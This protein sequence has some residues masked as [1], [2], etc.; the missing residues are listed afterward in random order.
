MPR[1]DA[2][3][4]C[5]QSRLAFE[6]MRGQRSTSR[7]VKTVAQ[8]VLLTSFITEAG[9]GL[10][11]LS[12]VK[13]AERR[14]LALLDRGAA[15]GDWTVPEAMLDLLPSVINEHDRQLREVRLGVVTAAVERL[16]RMI[17][18]ALAQRTDTDV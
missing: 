2:D 13:E 9:H 8:A 6:A 11:D 16:E 3:A 4:M 12:L 7:E 17:V 10:L 18:S 14:I 5:L 1:R 15:S